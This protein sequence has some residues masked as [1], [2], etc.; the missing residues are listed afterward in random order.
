MENIESWQSVTT[1]EYLYG[2]NGSNRIWAFVWDGAGR[3]GDSTT[4]L[5]SQFTL[6]GDLTSFGEDA[7]GELYLTTLTGNLYRI[8]AM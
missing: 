5:T 1:D 7:D 6:S 4:D 2:D 8:D 3:C